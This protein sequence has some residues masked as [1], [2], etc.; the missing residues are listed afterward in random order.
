MNNSKLESHNAHVLRQCQ[1]KQLSILEE[2]AR[3]CDLHG[4]QY[5]LDGGTLLGAV[6]HKGFIPWDDD[7]DIAMRKEDAERFKE[8]A[9]VELRDGLVLQTP[10]NEETKEPI[11]KVR[12]TDSFF[13]EPHDDF[14]TGYC[15][16]LY[17]DI[18]PFINYPNVSA[19][20]ARRYGKGI[21]KS[22]SILHSK[23]HYSLRSTAEWV[24]FG[25]RYWL[26]RTA[27]ALAFAFK[28]TD[29]YISN[30]LVNNGYGIMHRQDTVFPLSQIEFEG[31]TFS[32]PCHPDRYLTDLYGDFMR[33]PPE[34]KRKIHS[35]FILP[36]LG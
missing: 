33:I 18:F 25:C 11:L 30:V 12:D 23:H 16:G 29:T 28:K 9:S 4:I 34:D 35:V 13:V 3:I 36:Q 22:Y 2:I 24:Y 27:W 20:F 21:S 8:V 26:C 17:V 7:I 14:S 19:K 15:K 32:A 5:W 6:R 31:K 10:E 1:L